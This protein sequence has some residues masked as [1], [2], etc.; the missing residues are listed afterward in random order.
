MAKRTKKKPVTPEKVQAANTKGNESSEK[1]ISNASARKRGLSSASAIDSR[2][3]FLI[4]MSYA[5][6]L[7]QPV[8]SFQMLP[9]AFFGAVVI[10]ITRMYNYERNMSQ[11]YWSGGDNHL[12]DFFSYYKMVAILICAAFALIILLYRLFTQSFS[13][14]RCFAYIPMILYSA[15]VLVSYALSDYKEFSW[16]GYNDRFEGT[17]TLLAYM[18]MLFFVINT[19]NRERNIKWVIYPIAVSSA[20]L[21]LLGLTQ[22][23]DHDFFRTALGQKLIT[24]NN[25]IEM[26]ETFLSGGIG[27][28][29]SDAGLIQ[30]SYYTIHELIDMCKDIGINFLNFTFQNKEIYQT[31]Y[32]INYVSFYL[33]LLLPL[34]GMLFIRSVLRG[35]EEP[36]WKKLC[37]GA[38]FTLLVYN[39]IGSASSGG[40]LGMAFVVLA[41]VIILNKRIIAWWKPVTALLIIT[42]IMGGITY[43]RWIGEL[44]GAVKGTL[45]SNSIAENKDASET[46]D[47]RKLQYID[48]DG[49][50]IIIG[51]DDN[52][53]TITTY[54]DNPDA[55]KIVDQND[56]SISLIPTDVNPVLAFDDERF[57]NCY[58]Q[59]AQDERGNNYFLF[60]SD[61]QETNWAFRLTEDGV[62]YLNNLGNLVNLDKVPSIGWENNGSWGNGRGYI[63]SRTLPM[64]KDTIL[65]GHGADTYCLYFPHKDYVGKYNSGSFSKNVNIIVDKPHN[66]YMGAWIGTGGVSVLALLTLFGIYLIQS[67]R[68]YFRSR[69]NADDFPSFVGAGIFFGVV[70]FLISALVD[71]STVSV[72]PMFY[73]LLGTG[74][75]INMILKRQK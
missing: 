47:A 45:N 67:I 39:L 57:A 60:T 40:F 63:F 44:A 51:I 13:V 52:T 4:S 10:M 48:T 75:S 70:G 65:V 46:Q 26:T 72:M 56:K 22:A 35:K 68:L 14:K 9:I 17:V 64:M 11:F 59:P 3:D 30:E 43:D 69:F 41:A 16:L 73:T 29:L 6:P 1:G 19:A 66:M 53:L 49:N 61:G 5:T 18:V 25:T 58:L 71:D 37:W 31:V 32:N 55:I 15:M 7:G 62:Y 28:A 42:I 24:P 2:P 12:S 38:L 33:T 54:P 34:F 23:L 74:I 50:D 21:G 27:K 36:I 20:I 8:H